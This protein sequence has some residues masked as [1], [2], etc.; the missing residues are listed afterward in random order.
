MFETFQLLELVRHTSKKRGL[1]QKT[2]NAYVHHIKRFLEFNAGGDLS[3]SRAGKIQCF[4]QKMEADRQFSA[5]TQNQARCALLFLYRDVLEQELPPHFSEIKRARTSVRSSHIF[6]AVEVGR[7]LSHLRGAPYLIAALIYG[8]GLRLPEAVSLR[9]GDI[10]FQ[11]REI[12]VFDEPGRSKKRTTVLPELITPSLL[13]HLARVKFTHEDDC[14]S[15]FGRVGLP[16]SVLKRSPGA[17]RQWQWQYVF[18]AQKLSPA[19]HGIGLCRRHLAENTVQRAVAKAIEKAL[20]FK[21]CGCQTLRYSF[22]VRLFEKNHNVRTIQNLLG[23]KNL[24]T[25]MSYLNHQTGS[26][27]GILSPLDNP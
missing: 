19:E 16:P 12:V 23:H 5:S 21:P 27:K 14:L 15:G 1:S 9:V 6:S 7:I 22:A 10:D 8:S 26:E 2:E 13:R 11:K 17:A 24:K 25:T 3:E 20:I 4:L 18:P